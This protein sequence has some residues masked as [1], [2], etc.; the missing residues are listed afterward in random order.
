MNFR[1]GQRGQRIESERHRRA[2][3]STTRGV[4]SCPLACGLASALGLTAALTVPL[5]AVAG[6][7]FVVNTTGDPGPGGT[8]SLR[9]AVAAADTV[10]GNTVQFD[11]ALAGS[12]I[13]LATGEILVTHAMSIVGPGKEKLTISGGN[14]GRIF[15][16][17][18]FSTTKAVAISALTL[19]NGNVSNDAGGALK[20]QVCKLTLSN[21]RVTASHA[22]SGGGVD[23]DNGS[24]AHS[25][26]SGCSA[27][28]QGGGIQVRYTT[29]YNPRIDDST[30]SFNTAARGGG[31]VF[32]RNVNVSNITRDTIISQSTINN[33]S[34]T[35]TTGVQYGGGGIGV[36]HSQLLVYYSTIAQNN[37]Y[38]AG[39]GVSFADDYSANLSNLY[40]STIAHNSASKTYGNGVYA[41]AGKVSIGFSIVADNFNKYGLTDLS[42]SFNVSKSLVQSPGSATITGS[43]S[44]LG[45]DP[46][47]GPLD[48]NGGPT[49]TMLPDPG[50]QAI[51][52]TTSCVNQDQRGLPG[53]VNGKTDMGSVERQVP[54]VIIFRNGFESG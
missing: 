20:S 17:F 1:G 21:A 49:K 10:D 37:S 30:I 5:S 38:K 42:G 8:L 18:C 11:P 13:T 23:F 6:N 3:G 14:S 9:Q 53:C 54:E 12:T 26:V 36:L 52:A 43:G 25:I 31:G 28:E 24:I 32:L 44:L 22:V 46:H 41:P 7:T 51:D 39:G 45:V 34:V 4:R 16:L 48:E 33:N 2:A 47:L 15:N 40:R 27:D 19:A 50:S 29:G 35:A